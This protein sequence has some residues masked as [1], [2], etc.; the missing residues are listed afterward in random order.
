M[1]PKSLPPTPVVD[2]RHWSKRTSI[3]LG[4]FVGLFGLLVTVHVEGQGIFTKNA[5]LHQAAP[6][7][8]STELVASRR[9]V[10]E[11]LERYSS[12][13]SVSTHTGGVLGSITKRFRRFQKAPENFI[14]EPP[15]EVRTNNHMGVYLTSSSVKN[16]KKFEE[17]MDQL[18]KYGTKAIIFD[19][20]GS[21]VYFESTSAMAEEYKLENP[22]YDLP[23]IIQKLHDRG[24]YVMGRFIAVKDEGIT[25]RRP[26]LQIRHP[27]KNFVM[28]PGWVDPSNEEA[29]EYN[30]QVMCDL[31]ASG[32]DEVNMDYIRFTTSDVGNL[33]VF[34]GEEK[35]DKVEKFIIMAREAIDRCGPKT[36]LGISSYAILGWNYPANLATLGQDVVRFAKYLDVIS[37]MAYPQTF[38]SPEY[39][40][41]GKHPVSR[42]YWLV[43]RT[44]TGYQKLLGPVDSLK[45]RPWIQGYS[46]DPSGIRDEIQAVWDS[47]GCGFQVWNANNNYAPTYG[48]FA[49]MPKRPDHCEG[50]E[51]PRMAQAQADLAAQQAAAAASSASS[52]K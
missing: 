2:H 35:A 13:S 33:R 5:E 46:L 36:K 39:Y 6:G 28:G 50:L 21:R 10:R 20:K 16:M 37:P 17:T 34:S 40:I 11:A 18:E 25:S 49:M 15:K 22:M 42:N 48:A 4:S 27:T 52:T 51:D 32:I 47:G 38:T 41:P 45:L 19:V 8:E 31:A 3:L 14:P 24:F 9:Q 7:V 44:M 29:L 1:S 23:A 12:K 26:D 43:Y 30:R